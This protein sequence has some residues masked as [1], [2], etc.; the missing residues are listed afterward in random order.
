MDEE[1][2]LSFMSDWPESERISFHQGQLNPMYF[3]KCIE[4]ITTAFDF[5]PP[6]PRLKGLLSAL[7]KEKFT[8]AEM[9]VATDW[10]IAHCERFPVPAHFINCPELSRNTMPRGN[11]GGDQ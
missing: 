3:E 9:G 2:R 11:S 5:S 1:D 10:I 6:E 8:N 7:R 4:E